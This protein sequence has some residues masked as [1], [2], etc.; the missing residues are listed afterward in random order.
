MS[1]IKKIAFVLLCLFAIVAVTFSFL[2]RTELKVRFQGV[3]HETLY[4]LESHS[5]V[6]FYELS[7]LLSSR[8]SGKRQVTILPLDD[9]LDDYPDVVL[10]E[11]ATAIRS[12]YSG[13]AGGVFPEGAHAV[14]TTRKYSGGA[15]CLISMP[16]IEWSQAHRFLV[17]N[18]RN[19]RSNDWMAFWHEVGHC[20]HSLEDMQK[21]IFPDQKEVENHF[22]SLLRGGEQEVSEVVS[23]M[24]RNMT[25][26]PWELFEI[27]LIE[28]FADAF[29]Y[30]LSVEHGIDS[31][32]AY[33]HLRQEVNARHGATHYTLYFVDRV[34]AEI[35]KQDARVHTGK[36]MEAS[37][38]V[39]LN[40]DV[41]EYL[42]EILRQAKLRDPGIPAR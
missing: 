14:S 27:N 36:L 16:T 6:F 12:I 23:R 8:L 15:Y 39:I 1:I 22:L 9:M 42:D 21:R 11:S 13:Q 29:F 20:F 35:Q 25:D 7:E 5:G 3:D 24:T 17:F 33:R 37:E 10:A 2:F 26:S 4:H 19:L 31:R 40:L 41:R 38:R 32:V 30:V 18:E 28:G 34:I